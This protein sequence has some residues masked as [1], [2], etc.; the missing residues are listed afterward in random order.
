MREIRAEIETVLL[1]GEWGLDEISVAYDVLDAF[2]IESIRNFP[3]E[4][5][6]IAF[7]ISTN[8]SDDESTAETAEY[9]LREDL[10]DAGMFVETSIIWGEPRLE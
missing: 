4:P 7:T 9:C 3:D 2:H 10:A 8:F 5:A 1:E 6:K